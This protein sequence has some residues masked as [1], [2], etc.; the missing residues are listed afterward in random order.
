MKS[1]NVKD[2]QVEGMNAGLKNFHK[3][4][5]KSTE[6]LFGAKFSK[7]TIALLIADIRN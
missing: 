2:V 6:P 1:R 4:Y 7:I 3:Y 5:G